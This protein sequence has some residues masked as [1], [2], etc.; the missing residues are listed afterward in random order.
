MRLQNQAFLFE[1]ASSLA[2]GYDPLYSSR[3]DR[4][5][6]LAK[7]LKRRRGYIKGKIY[8]SIVPYTL[9]F[10]GECLTEQQLILML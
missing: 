3:A 2:K 6:W 8:H 10:I 1:K 4:N 5:L 7:M 9:H